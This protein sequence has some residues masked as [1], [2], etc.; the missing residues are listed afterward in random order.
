MKLADKAA[1]IR[2]DG[3]DEDSDSAHEASA[4]PAAA[5]TEPLQATAAR[6]RST[7]VAGITDRIA[8][9][10]Q[11]QDLQARVA[12]YESGQRVVLLDPR[13]VHESKWKNRHELSY[14]TQEYAELK[15]EIAAAGV[16]VVPIKVRPKGKGADGE[17]E[18]EVAY[19][20]RRN[21]CCLELDL[22]VAA[23]VEAMDDAQLFAEM[24]RENRNR[25]DLSP[26]EQGV[27]YKDAL[28]S[29][30]FASQKQMAGALNIS[31]GALSMALAL[32]SLPEEVINAFASPLELQYRWAADLN[33]ALERNTAGVMTQARLFC[34]MP[35]KPPAKVVLSALLAAGAG[36]KA[37]TV[38]RELRAGDRVVGSFAKDGKGGLS[39]KLK[40]GALTADGEKK[41]MEFLERL[42]K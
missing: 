24:E 13:R 30:L 34:D 39:L 26:W 7:A 17:D 25:V 19:G 4:A 1:K 38:K 29:K 36:E 11:V 3:L 5:A 15:D 41:L 6:P 12:T 2:F 8:L 21:R 35:E 10:H 14:S 33:E 23:I 32:A 28:E 40:K 42:L 31:S 22:K 16:N 37:Q 18:Y 20:R 9:H 27:M